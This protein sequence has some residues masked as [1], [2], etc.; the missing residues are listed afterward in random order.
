MS[1]RRPLSRWLAAFLLILSMG[2]ADISRAQDELVGVGVTPPRAEVDLDGRGFEFPLRFEN[3]EETPRE[4]VLSVSGLGH[5]LDGNPLFLEPALATEAISLSE[6]ELVLAAGEA[7]NVVVR[8]SIPAGERSL[9]ASVIALF[10]EPGREGGQIEARSRIASLLL[11]RGPGLWE[12]A[13]EAVDVSILPA[14]GDGPLRVFAAAENTGN[15]HVSPAGKIRLVKNGRTLDVVDLPAQTILPTYARRLVGEWTPP[16]K[17]T[18]RL[19]LVAIIE[20]P[21]AR[22]IGYVDFTPQGE[23]AV[24]GMK[25]GNLVARDDAGPLV[26]FVLSNTGTIPLGPTVSMAISQDDRTVAETTIEQPRMEP[27]ANEVVQWRPE[28]LE[29][30]VFLVSA[31]VYFRQQLLDQAATG[32]KLDNNLPLWVLVVGGALLLLLLGALI[33]W[34]RRRRRRA[35]RGEG[36]EEQTAVVAA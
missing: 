11:L 25:I 6:D 28:G 8:G 32:F 24:P 14:I 12:E 23:L 29:E 1:T 36:A 18:G 34:L 21:D 13:V 2:L 16:R 33:L 5:D 35:N 3:H 20:D 10:S 4:L 22:G 15:V 26:E 17:L 19:K 9:Y 7:R 31:E 30:G 27:A